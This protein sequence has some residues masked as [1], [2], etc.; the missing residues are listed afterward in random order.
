MAKILSD[1]AKK[2]GAFFVKQTIQTAPG[3][4][5]IANELNNG[6]W[7]VYRFSNDPYFF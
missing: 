2:N 3:S 6:A 1:E 7:Q 5:R 4:Q